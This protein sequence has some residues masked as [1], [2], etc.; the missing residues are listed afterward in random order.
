MSV[1]TLVALGELQSTSNYFMAGAEARVIW[2]RAA[3]KRCLLHEDAKRSQKLS[4]LPC[5][6]SDC[7]SDKTYLGSPKTSE[8]KDLFTSN[9][10]WSS[11]SSQCSPGKKSNMHFESNSNV[12]K[13]Y[14]SALDESFMFRFSK[15]DEF[16]GLKAAD[17]SLGSFADLQLLISG[18]GGSPELCYKQRLLP[19]QQ[20]ETDNSSSLSLEPKV[21]GEYSKESNRTSEQ[22][23]K[24]E[25]EVDHTIGFEGKF[26]PSSFPEGERELVTRATA[27]NFEG[28]K[29]MQKVIP[30]PQLQSKSKVSWRTADTVE[31]AALV[32]RKSLEH[33][34]NCDLPPSQSLLVSKGVLEGCELSPSKKHRW[35]MSRSMDR[36]FLISLLRGHEPVRLETQKLSSSKFVGPSETLHLPHHVPQSSRSLPVSEKIEPFI[37]RAGQVPSSEPRNSSWSAGSEN[38]QEGDHG[39]QLLGEALCH[40][41]TRA[42]EAEKAAAQAFLE[43]ERLARLFFQEASLSLTYRQWVDA[44]QAENKCLRLRAGDRSS[45]RLKKNLMKSYATFEPLSVT[46]WRHSRKERTRKETQHHCNSVKDFKELNHMRS[47]ARSDAMAGYKLGLAF[48]FGLG[49]AGAGLILGWSMGWILFAPLGN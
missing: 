33:M 19:D 27:V 24:H 28:S 12:H 35:D 45:G 21:T 31:L 40:S 34:E 32:A 47:S 18:E 22:S 46:H 41:Q 29:R 6:F 1:C 15:S 37:N 3:T 17:V 10:S 36:D 5:D 7:Q 23:I 11:L 43:K 13:D 9:D 16:D 14:R 8:E 42:R 30:V 26:Q 4:N 25:S 39:P 38:I 2:Q 48:A 49:L 20:R 44:L